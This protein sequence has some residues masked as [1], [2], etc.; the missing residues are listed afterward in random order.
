MYIAQTA[1]INTAQAGAPHK[2]NPSAMNT[3]VIVL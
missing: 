3:V 1:M 2:A